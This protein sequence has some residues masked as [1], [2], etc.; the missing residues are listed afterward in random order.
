MSDLSERRDREVERSAGRKIGSPFTTKVVGLS[1]I[2]S[3]PNNL[4][5]LRDITEGVIAHDGQPGEEAPVVLIRNPDN[6]YDANA[7]EVHVPALGSK[8][9]VGHLERPIAARLARELD[10]GVRWRARVESVLVDPDHP[11]RPGLLIKCG[12]V[13][14]EGE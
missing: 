9:M 4:L 2:K 1:F 11:D 5:E 10:A 14:T 13:T 8:A 3:Y 12:R 7:I 6:E